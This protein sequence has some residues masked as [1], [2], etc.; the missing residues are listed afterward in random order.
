MQHLAPDDLAQWLAD[1]QRPAPQLLD[2]REPW[3]FEYCHIE[4]SSLIPM[5]SVPARFAE[6]QA[7]APV[8]C[9]CHHGGRSMQV[10]L[11]LKSRGFAQV[12]NL[13]GGV[14]GW[15]ATVDASL[16]RY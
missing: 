16:K 15:A 2:V 7:D 5:A 13:S 4:G 14:D 3:E 1:A 8:V 11:F 10:A 12:Y 6:L 9:I